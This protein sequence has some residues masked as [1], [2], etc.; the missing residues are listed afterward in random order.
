MSKHALNSNLRIRELNS[1]ADLEQALRL[2]KEVWGS[3]EG[4]I[5][6]L[7]L[8]VATQNAGGIWLGGFDGGNL[9]GFVFAFPSLHLPPA[10]PSNSV[11]C[12]VRF[13]SHTLAVREPYRDSGIGYELKLAQRQKAL[14]LGITEMTWTFDPLRSRNAHLNFS[15]LGVISN[16]YR[17]N[18]YGSG[19][20]GP[21]DANG[22]D[23][24][25]VTWPMSERRTEQRLRGTSVRS[26][27]LD[28]LTHVSPL[29]RFRGDGVPVEGDLLQAL[30]RQRIA[31]E[32]PGDMERI[33]REDR[34]L[35][36]RWRLATR[37]AF[38]ESLEH[39]F[40]VTEFCRSIRGQQGP[41]AYLLERES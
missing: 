8:A 20:T 35:A 19:L 26:E 16:S 40:V 37:R 38:T 24:L 21:F 10:K 39:G 31:I 32:I 4:D 13:H 34:E 3:S 15:K 25:W 23:R 28:A 36:R 29:V 14:G 11:P 41:G 18:L 27:V 9:I 33:E 17:V 1:V 7:T 12:Q 2:E 5:T 6:P 22:T 30:A